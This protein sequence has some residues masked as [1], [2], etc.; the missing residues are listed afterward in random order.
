MAKK[1][2]TSNAAKKYCEKQVQSLD[3]VASFQILGF[4]YLILS[5]S[6]TKIFLWP[7]A[8]SLPTL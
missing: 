8:V 3:F 2:Y 1:K 5:A 6:I 7:F 4:N